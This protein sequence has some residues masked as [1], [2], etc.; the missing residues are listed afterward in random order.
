MIDTYKY[1]TGIYDTSKP[2]FEPY[3]R[4]KTRGHSRKLAKKQVK[5]QIRGNYF[6]ER[7]VTTWN[8]LPE[9]VVS[10]PM[11]NAFKNTLDA[12]WA[13]HPLRYNPTCY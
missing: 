7:V 2:H 6:A 3:T 11:L 12:H 8:S 9:S 4:R 13:N 1:V 5:K 10:A